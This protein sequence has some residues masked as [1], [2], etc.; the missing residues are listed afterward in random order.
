MAR[1]KAVVVGGGFS[2]CAAAVAASKAGAEV[3]LLER[4]DMLSGAGNRAGRMSYNGKLTLAE[5]SKALGA[6][7]VFEALESIILHR[8]NIVDE[9][10][11]YIY[12]TAAVDPTMQKLVKARGVELLLE[13]RAT[14]VEKEDGRLKAVRLESGEKVEGDVFIDCTG[15][16]G[17]MDGCIRYGKGCV[18]CVHRCPVF[19]NRLSIATKAGAPDLSWRRPDGTLGR[20]SPSV[21][22][23]KESLQPEIRERLAREGAISIPLPQELIDYSKED[24]FK[25][26]RGRHQIEHINIVD[27]GLGGKCVGMG[28]FTLADLRTIPGFETVVIEHPMGGEKFNFIN[29]LSMTPR[30]NSLAVKGFKNLL[31]GGEKSGP[32]GI[33][34]AISTGLV[35][36]H[37]AVRLAAGKDPV[38]LPR[39]TAIGD[40]IAFVS[41]VIETP[42]GMYKGCSAG[43]GIYFERMKELGLYN[44][45]ARFTHKRIE[46]LGLKSILS[47]RVI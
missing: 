1:V 11:A 22:V 6:G 36:G 4:T 46:D 24:H 9:E 3:V 18:M 32:G 20:L 47:Q 31:V 5:E 39:T 2:G 7:D 12:N 33:A 15:S 28:Y 26:I 13:G 37:N 19:G 25:G 29:H 40:F 27:I 43:H 38:V 16:F 45:D 44:P 35:A 21:T 34:E 17:G 14:D 42:E 41:E 30:E 10:H 23:Y 8:G